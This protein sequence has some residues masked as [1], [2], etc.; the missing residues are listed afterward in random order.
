MATS[1]RI[2][3]G[4]LV[5]LLMLTV[6]SNQLIAQDSP[7]AGAAEQPPADTKAGE[8]QKVD[9]PEGAEEAEASKKD[10][11]PQ[12]DVITGDATDA[13]AEVSP[14]PYYLI[15]AVIVIG[16]VIFM[17]KRSTGGG[18]GAP[19]TPSAP[20][21]PPASDAGDGAGDGGGD[22]AGAGE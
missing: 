11:T 10:S 15:G 3:L 16:V 22:G 7:G 14:M 21:A 20:A 17:M 19:S 2:G 6:S 18:A 9:I 5:A 1:I 4:L 12:D 13:G 8:D